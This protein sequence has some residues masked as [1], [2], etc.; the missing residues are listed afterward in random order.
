M[1]LDLWR[2]V[3]EAVEPLDLEV[4]EVKEAPGEVLV[5]LER[6]DERPISVAD[7][8]RASRAIEA[9]LDREDPIPGSYRLLV[10]SPGP[11]RPLFTRRHFERFQGLK[12][13]VPGPEGFTGRI[14]RLEGEEVVF[15]VGPEEKRLKIG[16]FRAQLAEWPEEP[17]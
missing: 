14:L 5:R 10:E 6:K 12:A 1:P 9:A 17:R 16:T 11:K 7:L 4:L 3:E 13:K 8:E 15:Q 2:L